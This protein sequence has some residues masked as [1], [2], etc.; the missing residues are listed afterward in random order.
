[1]VSGQMV[2]HVLKQRSSILC[3]TCSLLLLR[4][5]TEMLV[6]FYS[7]G[8][9]KEIPKILELLKSHI[10]H[11][12]LQLSGGTNSSNFVLKRTWHSR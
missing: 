10:S 9:Q 7:V 4:N 8:A 3:A 11:D 2:S 12:L 6:S 5:A 1:M